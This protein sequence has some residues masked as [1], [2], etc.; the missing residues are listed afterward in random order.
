MN[1]KQMKVL[2][3]EDNPG[4]VRLIKEALKK[5]GITVSLDVTTDGVEAMASLR[6][7]DSYAHAQ[8]PQVIILDLNL[9]RKDGR[10]TLAEIKTDEK[11]RRIPV[12]VFT[13]SSAEQD[14]LDSYDHNANCYITKPTNLPGFI[15]AVKSMESFWLK[16][17]TLPTN[18]AH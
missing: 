9:P 16:S 7:Q 2:L 13:T 6:Q 14:I 5:N 12:L 1:A 10:E 11:F 17:A 18:G 15:D 3:I 8:R 4:D